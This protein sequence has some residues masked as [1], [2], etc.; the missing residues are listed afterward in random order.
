MSLVTPQVFIVTV[1]YDLAH[2]A[3]LEQ[4]KFDLIT[5]HDNNLIRKPPTEHLFPL[6]TGTIEQQI[7]LAHFNRQAK[8]DEII[9]EMDKLNVRPVLSPEFLALVKTYPDLQRQ[10]PLG[11]LGSVWVLSNRDR[12]VLSA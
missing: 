2:E 11:G 9:A 1:N 3:Q 6:P 8:R 12:G 10:F 4:A 5:N 7:T